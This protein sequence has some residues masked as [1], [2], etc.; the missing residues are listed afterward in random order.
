MLTRD[1]TGRDGSA[2][3]ACVF[4]LWFLS[5]PAPLLVPPRHGPVRL[6]RHRSLRPAPAR[7]RKEV[8]TL[9]AAPEDRLP[10]DL[11]LRSAPDASASHPC[12]LPR[13]STLALLSRVADE[14]GPDTEPAP[15][16]SGCG[17]SWLPYSDRWIHEAAWTVAP[18]PRGLTPLGP[19]QVLSPADLRTLTCPID[20]KVPLRFADLSPAPDIPG[21]S[22]ASP[23]SPV[24]V[25]D[26]RGSWIHHLRVGHIT[27]IRPRPWDLLAPHPRDPARTIPALFV[28]L[29]V[30]V[31][32]H[33]RDLIGLG[34]PALLL[35]PGPMNARY[36]RLWHDL[37]TFL[38]DQTGIAYGELRVLIPLGPSATETDLDSSLFALRD[39]VCGALQVRFRPGSGSAE[40]P[41]GLHV[42]A[43]ART[44]AR[45]GATHLVGTA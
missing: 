9:M 4:V 29:S 24:L 16:R 45:R 5:R 27:G 31:D 39:R 33:A 20:P 23:P 32:E 14:F 35:I 38:E 21:A 7:I 25:G 6:R 18:W 26:E 3:R 41:V 2:C 22:T 43:L 40:A 1:A 37:L 15:P 19:V 17:R 11:D 28:D 44:L 13:A 30:Y 10:F 12:D 42:Q 36:A 34:L 8:D